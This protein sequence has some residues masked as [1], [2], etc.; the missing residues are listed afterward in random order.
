MLRP[1]LVRANE[2]S[3]AEGT[4]RGLEAIPEIEHRCVDPEQLELRVVED[5]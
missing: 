3:K 2:V 5:L 1:L 4:G